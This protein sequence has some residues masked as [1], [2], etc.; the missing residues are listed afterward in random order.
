MSL[1]F[2]EFPTF[3]K[4]KGYTSFREG[5][6][7]WINCVCEELGATTGIRLF[8]GMGITSA[9]SF[10]HFN[11]LVGQQITT[12]K[13]WSTALQET[14]VPTGISP[15]LCLY[16]LLTFLWWPSRS[17]QDGETCGLECLRFWESRLG[18]T[19]ETLMSFP[20][21]SLDSW[22]PHWCYLIGIS[23]DSSYISD[24]IP[25]RARDGLFMS[26]SFPGCHGKNQGRSGNG[27]YGGKVTPILAEMA[28][29][30][31]ETQPWL[32]S[33]LLWPVLKAVL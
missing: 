24:Q 18:V 27:L 26:V 19:S 22:L 9:H 16:P 5:C 30:E 11:C 14:C 13:A 1:N 6:V 8:S 29:V 32:W 12:L 25:S 2:F 31:A 10:S 7:Q 21:F 3:L 4:N 33:L 20:L 28:K 15:S 17:Q 23:C